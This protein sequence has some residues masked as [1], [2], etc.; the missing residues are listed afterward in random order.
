MRQPSEDLAS[1]AGEDCSE[2]KVNRATT[3]K[4]I[5]VI[6]SLSDLEH[7]GSEVA[8]ASVEPV[9]PMQCL[10]W[11]RICI[12]VFGINNEA[13]RILAVGRGRSIA[14][15]PFYQRPHDSGRLRMIGEA[16]LFEATDFLYAP[17]SDFGALADAIAGT[18]L[19]LRLARIH[20]RSPVLEALRRAYAG[21]AAVRLRHATAVPRIDLDQ[22]WL[23]PELR[24][25]AGRRSD[26]RRAQR[27]AAKIGEVTT[28]IVCPSLVELQQ[29]LSEAISVEADS[30]KTPRGTALAVDSVQRLFYARFTQAACAQGRLR[31][32]FLR[33]GGRAAAMQ[34][35]TVH[36]NRFWLH[37]IGYSSVFS[38]ASPGI[39]LMGETISYAARCGLSSFEF[40]G[41]AEPWIAVWTTKVEPC[42]VFHAYPYTLAGAAAFSRDATAKIAARSRSLLRPGA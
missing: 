34:I 37:K 32:C 23:E 2:E 40:L 19:G 25:N 10:D 29:L 38:R 39:L 11:I 28:E 7:L 16:E 21:R 17:E 9:S 6:R 20:A 41:E 4:D 30:W 35:A 12:E 36:G 5:R 24:L 18:G 42:V 1:A 13:L 8:A 14:I 15:A 27:I 22:S 3:A 26:F 33:I 31:L